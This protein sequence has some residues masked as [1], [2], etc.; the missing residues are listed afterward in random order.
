M[1]DWLE[2]N[3]EEWAT[4]WTEQWT[5]RR[6]LDLVVQCKL[7]VPIHCNLFGKH[8]FPIQ[9]HWKPGILIKL[10]ICY[11]FNVEFEAFKIQLIFLAKRCQRMLKMSAFEELY[12]IAIDTRARKLE[13]GGWPLITKFM[14]KIFSQKF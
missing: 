14:A 3:Q 2:T 9:T 13:E 1:R 6:C 8:S 7:I 4:K 12:I 10:N 5:G 11:K